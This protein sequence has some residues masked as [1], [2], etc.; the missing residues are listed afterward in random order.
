[1]KFTL[2]KQLAVA[3]LAAL[4]V[5]ASAH[6]TLFSFDP[7]GA[8]GGAPIAGA[9]TIDQAPGSAIAVG[10]VTAIYNFLAGS[11][12]TGFTLYYQANL[13]S[14]QDSASN[15]LFSNG[16]GG[17]Y[18]TFVA[19][20][21][22]TVTGAGTIGGTAVATFAHDPSNPVN[23]FTMYA[24]TGLGNNLTVTGFV[25]TPILTGAGGGGAGGGGGASGTAPPAERDRG[26]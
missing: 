8:G 1:M 18:F 5:S 21:G 6:A 19:G 2:Q 20:F 15:N 4:G 14:I 3:V 17:Q 12:S 24:T 7:D 10:G 11:G 26:P 25:G 13:N 16:T 9:A 22:E 23:F